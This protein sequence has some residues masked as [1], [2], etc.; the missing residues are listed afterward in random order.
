MRRVNIESSTRCAL[1]CPKCVRTK[2]KAKGIPFQEVGRDMPRSDFHKLVDYFHERVTFLGTYSDPIFYPYLIEALIDTKDKNVPV[3][4][5]TAASQKSFEWYEEAFRANPNARWVFGLDGLPEQSSEYRINQDGEKLFE[6]MLTAKFM[7]LNPLWKYIVFNYNE[8]SI[9]K[10]KAI[11]AIHGIE[12]Q[13]VHSN[14][15]DKY[16]TFKPSE[17]YTADKSLA[18][19]QRHNVHDG[20]I[21]DVE[22]PKGFAPRCLMGKNSVAIHYSGDGFLSPCCWITMLDGNYREE[23][24]SNLL[25]QEHLKLENNDSVED[26]LES[27]EWT[28]FFEHLE[29]HVNVPDRCLK[30]C[31]NNG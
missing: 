16:D 4:L 13:I 22:V 2:Y 26:V 11:A 25:F 30:Q 28:T 27:R 23:Y 9:G 5:H 12:I 7:G 10:A 18:N 3:T 15:W 24:P 8:N 19:F 20:T 1:E 31:W 17:E 6:V 29:N 14:R 21:R